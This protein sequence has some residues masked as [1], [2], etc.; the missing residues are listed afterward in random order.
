[1]VS[2]LSGFRS[3]QHCHDHFGMKTVGWIEPNL[4]VRDVFTKHDGA[5]GLACKINRNCEIIGFCSLNQCISCFGRFIT[6]LAIILNV[7]KD[8]HV[9]QAEFTI[10]CEVCPKNTPAEQ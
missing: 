2:L 1:M 7:Y 5:L 8:V 9:T 6:D 3:T 10:R 4:R